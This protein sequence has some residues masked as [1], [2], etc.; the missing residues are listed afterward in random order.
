MLI[1]VLWGAS[2][3]FSLCTPCPTLI[4]PGTAG[5]TE[6]PILL[7]NVADTEAFI[8]DKEVV[9]LGFFQVCS[10][11]LPSPRCEPYPTLV[12]VWGWM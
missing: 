7:D 8:S 2:L 1:C 5:T 9:V 4:S 10:H 3:S 6:K 11:H 12:R